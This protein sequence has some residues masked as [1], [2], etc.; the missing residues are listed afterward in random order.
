[1]SLKLT[2][3][4]VLWG[5]AGAREKFEDMASQLIHVE[6]PD[7]QRIRIVNGDGGLDSFEGGLTDPDGIDVYQVKYF[8]EKLGD[9]QKQQIRDSFAT[10][11]DSKKF[12]V[13]SWTLCLPIDM[14]INETKWFEGW[15]QKEAGTGI[16]IRKP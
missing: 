14:S 5:D 2:Q 9:T 10:A 3:L 8:P 12:K 7:S 15:A 11:R 1:M 4:Q 16:D 13:K 6:K